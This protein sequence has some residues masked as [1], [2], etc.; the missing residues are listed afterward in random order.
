MVRRIR[1]RWPG[2]DDTRAC[3]EL[4]AVEPTARRA[5]PQRCKQ[6]LHCILLTVIATLAPESSLSELALLMVDR[7]LTLGAASSTLLLKLEKAARAPLVSMA[8]T[9]ITFSSDAGRLGL[10]SPS[11]PAAAKKRMSFLQGAA[12]QSR[13]ACFSAGAT[14]QRRQTRATLPRACADAHSGLLYSFLNS[15]L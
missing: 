14:R 9:D 4:Q 6:Q 13:R 15:A 1:R 8:P 2:P 5:H 10:E 7:S 3:Q 11:S 12:E